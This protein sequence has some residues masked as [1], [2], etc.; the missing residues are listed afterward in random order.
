MI[1][2]G[3]ITLF[4]IGNLIY[5]KEKNKEVVDLPNVDEELLLFFQG[6]VDFEKIIN[7]S[8]GDI[9]EDNREDLVVVYKKDNN[10]NHMVVVINDKNNMY[11]TTPKPAPKEDVKIEFKNIDN[12]DNMEVIISGSKN[13]NVG[14]GVY[15]FENN[16]LIDLFGEGMEACC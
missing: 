7:Y 3:I 11:V 4:L 6:N 10:N 5:S 12:K 8:Q 15:R 9:N 14:Y 13:G 1:V 2:V 16:E